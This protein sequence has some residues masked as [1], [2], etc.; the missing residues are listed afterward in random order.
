MIDTLL[1][2]LLDEVRSLRAENQD[3]REQLG[4]IE[5]ALPQRLATVDEAAEHLNLCPTTIQRLCRAGKLP[6]KRSGRKWLIDLAAVRAL[7]VDDVEEAAAEARG[8]VRR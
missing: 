2:Q 3:M 8:S 4:R 1:A 5:L 6:T 7:D